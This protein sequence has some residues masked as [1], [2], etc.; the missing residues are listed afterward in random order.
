MN[1]QQ[2]I[3][4]VD[5]SVYAERPFAGQGRID[6]VFDKAVAAQL[7]WAGRSLEERA[8]FC[9]KFCDVL[10]NHS[11]EIA[12]ELAWSMGRPVIQAPGE[13]R[14]C[15]ERAR[16][17]IEAAEE[18]LA[19]L[20]PGPK[21]GFRR[22]VRRVPLGVVFVIAPWNY[23]FLTAVNTIIPAIMAGNA[24]V[25]KHAA[26]TQLVAER[27]QQAFDE[28]G[29]PEGVF[30][31]L[32]V[33]GATAEA[34]VR[35]ARVAHVAFTGSVAVGHAVSRA[36]AD[37]FISVGLELGGK[38]PA[39]VRAD[40]DIGF[41]AENLVDGAFFNSGQSCCGIERIYVDEAVFEEFV[42]K[43]VE[44]TA[45]YRLGNPTKTET[46]L[47]PVVS[48]KAAAFIRAQVDEAVGQGA[49]ALIS[50]KAFEADLVGSPYM[51]PQIL[52]DV[53]HKMRV[54][55]EET[56]GPVVGIMK[57][58]SDEEAI[59]LMNDSEYGLTAAVFSADAAAAEAIGARI[60]TGTVFLNR[61]DY[62]DPAL[63]WAGVKDTGRGHTLSMWGYEQLTRPQ[64]FH[65][66][67][68]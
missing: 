36:A 9:G 11:D 24:V 22:Y 31:H 32:H 52:V 3:S 51:A 34:L 62:L 67:L 38:D 53:S 30:Q 15:V 28:A 5:G 25:L 68:P 33:A 63:A 43:A 48:A 66:R 6:A 16:F 14:G 56:F 2:T 64:S 10:L 61:C 54:M 47:G 19:V 45:Q 55:T 49:R 29:L 39:Y 42:S 50:P 18:G 26:Q 41:A 4:P 21:T 8:V 12:L 57:V 37:R 27:F 58:G 17:M 20:D 44:V 23:P 65:L 40:A 59:R 1:M 35:D 60:A 13:V 7:D 46:N